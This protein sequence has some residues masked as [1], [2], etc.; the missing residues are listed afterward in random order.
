MQAGIGAYVRLSVKG[1]GWGRIV[2]DRVNEQ[3]QDKILRLP[4]T[5]RNKHFHSFFVL[6]GLM[7]I[8]T[9]FFKSS[10][11]VVHFCELC[12]K[13]MKNFCAINVNGIILYF[14]HNPAVCKLQQ[15]THISRFEQ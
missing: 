15:Y 4:F 7:V 1:R 2:P 14:V 12:K 11:K 6:L 5:C 10:A 3:T 13:K 9:D 8:V